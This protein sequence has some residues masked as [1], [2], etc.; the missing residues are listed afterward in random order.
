MKITI[1]NMGAKELS[2]NLQDYDSIIIKSPMVLRQVRDGALK[3]LDD[4]RLVDAV[5]SLE[6]ISVSG[7]AVRIEETSWDDER[8]P[9]L[10]VRDQ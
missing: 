5:S 3:D 2:V 7:K 6:L 9:L 10:V 4:P 8:K 1:Q